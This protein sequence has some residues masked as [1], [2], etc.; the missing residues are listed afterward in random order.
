[1]KTL[2]CS[3]SVSENTGEEMKREEGERVDERW[4]GVGVGF[5][6]TSVGVAG[7][8]TEFRRVT[9]TRVRTIICVYCTYM[10]V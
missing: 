10:Y 9:Q 5:V 6:M 4:W 3:A 1:M 2:V 7:S 8:I